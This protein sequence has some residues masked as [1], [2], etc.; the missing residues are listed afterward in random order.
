MNIK[1]VFTFQ[2]FRLPAIFSDTGFEHM[3]D[4]EEDTIFVL[5]NF[6]GNIFQKLHRA[7]SR[8]V[9]PPVLIECAR[10]Q[11]VPITS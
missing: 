7:G 9:G 5:D 11:T 4:A 6:E 2:K 8:I 1:H 3:R 10:N